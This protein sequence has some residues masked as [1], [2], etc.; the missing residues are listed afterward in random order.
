MR[1][2]RSRRRDK[3]LYADIYV[4]RAYIW[5]VA[6]LTLDSN[7]VFAIKASA[8]VHG[9]MRYLVENRLRRYRKGRAYRI[10]MLEPKGIQ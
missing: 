1:S 3:G 2:Q 9:C 7:G 5:R 10:N 8:V 6:S 4:L